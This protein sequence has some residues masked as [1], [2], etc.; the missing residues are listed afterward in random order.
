MEDGVARYLS[1][2]ESWKV[3]QRKLAQAQPRL[4]NLSD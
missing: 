1:L 2:I 4:I 3:E